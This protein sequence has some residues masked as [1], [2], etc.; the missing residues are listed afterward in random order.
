M[1]FPRPFQRKQRLGSI[2]AGGERRPIRAAL[3]GRRRAGGFLSVWA[4]K[5]SDRPPAQTGR[6][7]CEPRRPF[8]ADTEAIGGNLNNYSNLPVKTLWTWLANTILRCE[9][10]A[11]DVGPTVPI[12]AIQVAPIFGNTKSSRAATRSTVNKWY[13]HKFYVRNYFPCLLIDCIIIHFS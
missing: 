13:Y 12:A 9:R 3:R 4:V 8:Y 10:P 1:D 5:G 6:S 11:E 2:R 7:H